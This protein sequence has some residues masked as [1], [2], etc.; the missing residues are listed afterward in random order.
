M[1]CDDASDD[2]QPETASRPATSRI[3][4]PKTLERPDPAFGIHAGPVVF[5]LDDTLFTASSHVEGDM[6]AWRRVD[7]RVGDE[8][9]QYLAKLSA[10]SRSCY[11]IVDLVDY[12][13][14]WIPR[15]KTFE[16]VAGKL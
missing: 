7:K 10:V 8:N 13:V 1:S 9:G 4:S 12:N 11:A 16:N 2:R 5:R 15:R 6:G 14:R 3:A